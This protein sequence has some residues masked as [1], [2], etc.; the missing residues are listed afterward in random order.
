MAAT[1]PPK[2]CP[3]CGGLQIVRI[4]WGYST[5]TDADSEAIGSGQ[6][7]LGLNRRYYGVHDREAVPGAVVHRLEK[8]RLPAW[9]CL[10]CSPRWIDLHRL[11][12]QE[13]EKE[14]AKEI[15]CNAGDFEKA[16]AILHA[17]KRLENEHSP[18][19]WAILSVLARSALIEEETRG[20]SPL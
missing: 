18:E 5:L 20:Q 12:E 16:A 10:D 8:S 7:I 2:T 11:A 3:R 15:A 14:A 1:L 4:L 17:Q 13:L 9:A 19:V 6:A